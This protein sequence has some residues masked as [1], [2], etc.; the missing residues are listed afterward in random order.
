M[1]ALKYN[2]D[3]TTA[4]AA[5]RRDFAESEEIEWRLSAGLCGACGGEE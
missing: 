1:V 5:E 4:G 2:A 3:F